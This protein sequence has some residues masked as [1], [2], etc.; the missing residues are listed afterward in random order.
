MTRHYAQMRLSAW[1]D[2]E[3]LDLGPAEQ[4]LYW[5]ALTSPELSLAGV[6]DWRPK[7]LSK[8]ARG[9]TPD[10]IDRTATELVER[11]YFVIDEDTEEVLIR[12]F[13]RHDGIV[14]SPNM[15]TGM[16]RAYGSIA[17]PVLRRVLVHELQR[18]YDENPDAPGWRSKEA[19]ALLDKAATDP[20]AD[21]SGTP[22]TNRSGN[23]SGKGSRNPSAKGSDHLFDDPSGT[24]SGKGS[25]N[26]SAK[27]CP[28]PAPTP[29]PL[30]STLDDSLR[31]S[32]DAVAT[33]GQ[34]A[35]AVTASTVTA[36]WV[37]AITA[38]D[39]TPSSGQKSAV[40]KLAK[41]L[42]KTNDPARVLAA[43]QQAGAKGQTQI[44]RELTVMNGRAVIPRP[45]QIRST[46]DE[47]VAQA[48]ALRGNGSGAPS[49]PLRPAIGGTRR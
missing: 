34:D 44:D 36:A 13:V 10:L 33:P 9:W 27:G 18:L 19:L 3:W 29:A 32:G 2:D 39:V 17:S 26:P 38:N 43:A 30:T 45:G 23:P 42:L 14:N 16:A 11:L 4:H 12:S 47:R 48:L 22:S 8:R 24:P 25:G 15:M 20:A 49:Q 21:R 41:E 28:T 40:G 31:E 7:R 6:T 37:D 35:A 1:S 5:V 46:T